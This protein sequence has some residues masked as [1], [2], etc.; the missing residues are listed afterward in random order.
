MK[1]VD[2]EVR[3]VE[4]EALAVE[5]EA[6][7]LEREAGGLPIGELVLQDLLTD[8]Q[9]LLEDDGSPEVTWQ[10]LLTAASITMDLCKALQ[11]QTP[12]DDQKQV[13]AAQYQVIAGFRDTIE[14]QIS[15]PPAAAAP[16][17]AR[18][19]LVP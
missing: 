11:E 12:D 2:P 9:T 13:L 5:R 17:A 16:K 18:G 8:A 7:A 14:Q 6:F 19:R 3:N 10:E 15:P 4:R 1:F